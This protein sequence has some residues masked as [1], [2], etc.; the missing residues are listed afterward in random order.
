MPLIK[1]KKEQRF[2]FAKKP[3]IAKDMADYTKAH[4]VDLKKLPTYA[5]N[6]PLAKKG[7]VL[8]KAK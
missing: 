5:H 3:A 7:G 8:S 2:L 4:G 6:K 1:S